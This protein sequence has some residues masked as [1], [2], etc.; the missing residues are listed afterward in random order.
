MAS[1]EFIE[2]RIAGKEKEIAKLEA[3]IER[4]NKAKATNWEVNP[5]YYGEADLR[6]AM[7]DLAIAKTALDGYRNDL[8]KANEK[9]ESRN[10]KVIVDFL[11]AWKARNKEYYGKMFPKYIEAKKEYYKLSGEITEKR[12]N[13][14]K[15][16]DKEI[17]KQMYNELRNEC[18]KINKE[19]HSAWNWITVYEIYKYNN[20]EN[21]W[22]FEL[23]LE[24]LTKDLNEEANRK[25]DF[26]I[27][28][29]NAIVG[30]ITDAGNLEIGASGD[31][32]GY[33]VGTN[34]TAK[35]NTIGAGGYNI[36]CYHFRT[37]IHSI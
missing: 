35:V 16:T 1:I 23:D 11:E 20:K 18:D 21:R 19:F 37:L 17:R 4:I 22:D 5:Y 29:T 25:Y 13:L 24:K 3:K 2:K 26:I 15:I 8:I 10:V 14:Y 12:N 27:E 36:Q 28:R 33:I 31:L 32:N 7:N 34:G 6:Y 30:K 9:A